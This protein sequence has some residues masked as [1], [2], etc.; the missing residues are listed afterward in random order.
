MAQKLLII[1]EHQEHA[2]ERKAAELDIIIYRKTKSA[3]EPKFYFEFN[4]A[5][6]I[7]MYYLVNAMGMLEQEQTLDKEL[8][9]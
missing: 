3:T 1:P 4:V 7:E 8:L 2:F 5:N 6:D 9:N